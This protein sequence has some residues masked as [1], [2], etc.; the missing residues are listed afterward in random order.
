M[1]TFDTSVRPQDDFF[2]YINNPWLKQNPIP[3]SETS[4]GSFYVLRD[5]STKAIDNI[6]KDLSARSDSTLDHDQQLVK[7]FFATALSFDSY[8]DNHL[9]TL[10]REMEKVSAISNNTELARYLGDAHRAGISPFWNCYVELDDRDSHM[11]VLR[12]HQSG[13]GLPNRDY[14]LEKTAAM[15][16]VRLAYEALWSEL[17]PLV[18]TTAPSNWQSV[19]GIETEL[20]RVSW[21]DVALRD[22]EKSY[23][24][25]SLTELKKEF[26]GFDWH[27]YFAGLGWK[28]PNDHIVVDQPP[29]FTATLGILTTTPLEDIKHYL[30]WQLVLSSVSWVSNASADAM[31][32]FYG[33]VI[34]GQK[35]MKPLW[36]RV[37]MLADSL[38]IGEALG[39]EYARR[40]FPETSKQA[41]SD[42]VEEIRAA[43]HTRIERLDWMKPATKRRAHTKL[44]NINVFVGYPS[45]WKDLSTLAFPQG[46]LLETL[47]TARRFL[48][49]LEMP[50]IGQKPPAE[51]WFMNAHTVNAY[52]HPNRLEIVFP[53]AILQP[54]FYDSRASHASNLGGIGAVIGHELTHSFDDQGS[55]FDENGN[56]NSWQDEDER[57]RFNERAE[58]IVRQAD[59]FETVPGTFLQGKLIL[60]EAIAD[61]GGLALAVEALEATQPN[62]AELQAL[63][64]NFARCECGTAT[65]ERLIE[66]AKTDPHPP[67]PFRVNCVVNHVDQFYDTYDVTPA[68]T[69]YLAPGDRAKIW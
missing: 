31:F 11:Q 16:K 14:Y 2:G 42:M 48:H 8:K 52:N 9:K 5:N 15:K 57:G 12:L 18:G 29:F 39:K 61:I 21:T 40:H 49:D 6:I 7:T 45:V 38:V 19:L 23:N 64:V 62:K 47:L 35:E 58:F 44:D 60:G 51:E 36:K 1:H 66:F 25:Y 32:R 55:L 41:V 22:V 68:D 3:P 13:L 56:L 65:K 50:K 69:L 10:A 17:A 30:Q 27:E 4:W 54:P 20:A 33:T 53:A 63:F 34:G 28:S 37:V 67:S 24:K 46:N 26:S 43:Y 59:A